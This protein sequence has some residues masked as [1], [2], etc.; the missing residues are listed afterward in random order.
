MNKLAMTIALTICAASILLIMIPQTPN[1]AK[2]YSCSSSS[3]SGGGHSSISSNV[4]GS[5]GSCGT[6][7]GSAGPNTGSTVDATCSAGT[8][9]C[10]S[11]TEPLTGSSSGGGSQS[12][13]SASSS[14]ATP[15]TSI[16]KTNS[17]SGKGGIA[18]SNNSP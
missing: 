9:N 13:C 15:N 4:H 3:S 10:D 2:A 5:T 11:H 16:I 6:S 7:S 14:A 18:C 1:I 8:P 12:S 17:G